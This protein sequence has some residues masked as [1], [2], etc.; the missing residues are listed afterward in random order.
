MYSHAKANGGK[1]SAISKVAALVVIVIILAA[2][3]IAYFAFYGGGGNATTTGTSSSTGSTNTPTSASTGT[4]VTTSTC[5]GN[6][7]QTN[8]TATEAQHGLLSVLISD[9]PHLTDGVSALFITYPNMYL[10]LAGVPE[11]DGWIQVS[12][13]G[14][15][16]LLGAVNI[17]ETVAFAS[18]PADEYNMIRFNVSSATVTYNSQNYSALVQ[19]GNLTIH[20]IGTLAMDPARPSALIIDV[21]PFLFNFG[22]ITNPSFVLKPSAISFCAPQGFATRQMQYI[23]NRFQFQANHTWFW[24]YRNSYS[25]QVN[26]TGT[27]LSNSSLSLAVENYGSQSLTINA[28]TITS[29]QGTGMGHGYGA[30]S[31]PRGLS[32]SAVFLLDQSATL[33]QLTRQEYGTGPM[34]ISTMI[35]ESE[36]YMVAPSSSTTLSYSGEIQL[37]L[38]LPPYVQPGEIVPGQQYMISLVGDG[39][40]SSYVVTAS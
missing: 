1:M 36:G 13:S 24:Q 40:C 32:G 26:I 5:T 21:S 39:V 10:H 33:T 34:E 14:S 18:I 31:M 15:I 8:T 19:N 35:W 12:S 6:C 22:S 16:E 25:P 3:G 38:R 30:S 7:T 29:L 28:I 9:P 27:T 17:G 23:G 37:S 2:A 4:K 11:A 20:L